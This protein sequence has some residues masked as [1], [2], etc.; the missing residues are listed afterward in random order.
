MKFLAKLAVI[1]K[2]GGLA[3]QFERP[4]RGP[5]S[6]IETTGRRKTVQVVESLAVNRD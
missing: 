3:E 5:K 2:L 4:A 1:S 6:C